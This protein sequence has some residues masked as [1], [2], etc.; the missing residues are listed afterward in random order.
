M[1]A[2]KRTET[3]VI[4]KEKR[5]EI[6]HSSKCGTSQRERDQALAGGAVS[7]EHPPRPG[8]Q[9]V[10][11]EMRRKDWDVSKPQ[12]PSVAQSGIGFHETDARY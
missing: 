11:A 2:W 10:S 6:P 3:S 1:H 7:M 5:D 12:S 9:P 8:A 4:E